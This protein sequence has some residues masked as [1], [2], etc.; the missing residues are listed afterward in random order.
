[1]WRGCGQSGEEGEESGHDK[2]IHTDTADGDVACGGGGEEV[3]GVQGVMVC[4]VEEW[5]VPS[6]R[7]CAMA[8]V[9]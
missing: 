7:F 4:V 5:E 8:E 3:E 1:M 2:H 6:V 9:G